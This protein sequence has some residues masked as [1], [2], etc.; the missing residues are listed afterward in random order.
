MEVEGT[1]R[2]LVIGAQ[3][4]LGALT[5]RAFEAAGW[6]VRSAARRPRPGQIELD[7]DRPDSIAAAV[8]EQ[9]SWSIPCRIADLPAERLCPRARRRADQ[10]LRPPRRRGRSLRAVA[11]GARGTVVMNAGLAPGVTTIVAADLLSRH[12]TASEL[13]IVFTLSLAVPR[14]PAS[15]D[16]VHRGL[17]ARAAS[18]NRA[19]STPEPVRRAPLPGLWRERRRLARRHRRGPDRS[20]VRLHRRAGGARTPARAQR[21]RRDVQPAEIAYRDAKARRKRRRRRRTGRALGRGRFA[22]DDGWAPERCNA[23]GGSLSA[24][25]STVVFANVLRAEPPPLGCFDPEEIWTLSGI[26]AK[27]QDAGIRVVSH[28]QVAEGLAR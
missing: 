23:W 15:A 2:A 24:A 5:V 10:R 3:G 13:E 12:P 14:G 9:S 21:R 1:N 26:E 19:D 18:P 17:T 6:T 25:R 4:V 8:D 28:P 20:S 7:L 22:T 27:L 11:G 16:F